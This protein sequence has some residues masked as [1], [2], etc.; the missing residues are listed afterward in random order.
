MSILAAGMT[1]PRPSG[2]LYVVLAIMLVL[3]P[4]LAVLQYQWIGEVSQAERQKLV[5]HLNQAGMQFAQDFNREIL[6]VLA[7]FQRRGLLQNSDLSEWLTQRYDQA[8]AAYPNL[9]RDAFVAQRTDDGLVLQRFAPVGGGFQTT[10]WPAEFDALRLN[11]E[12][13]GR[14]GRTGSLMTWDPLS[15]PNPTFVVAIA[16]DME[17]RSG[18]GPRPGPSQATAWMLLEWN[19]KYFLDEFIPTIV[20]RHFTTGSSADYRVAIVSRGQNPQVIYKSEAGLTLAEMKT[21]DLRIPLMGPEAGGRG[22]GPGPGGPP[23]EDRR[24]RPATPFGP[25]PQGGFGGQRGPGGGGI[26][27]GSWELLVSHRAGSLDSAITSL[28]RRNLAIS[29]GILLLLASS[30]VLVVT[31]SHRARAL[32]QL[33]M[34]FVARVSHE[35]RTPLAIIRS[36]AY[37][38]ATGVVSDEKDVR[39]YASMVQSEGQRLSTMV[40]QILTFSRTDSETYNVKPVDIYEI[41]EK[42]LGTM[43]SA[44]THAH[45]EVERNIAGNLPMVQA[46]ER[47]LVECLQNLLSNA[48]KYGRHETASRILVDARRGDA[49]TVLLSIADSGP[50]IEPPDLPHIFEPFF[51]GKN[52]RSDTPGSG[53]GLNLVRRMMNAQG[54][55]VTVES[56]PGRGARFTLHLTAVVEGAS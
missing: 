20:S 8:I 42:A 16:Q 48:L 25:P 45:Y 32:A 52:A 43:A 23:Q 38:V 3:L 12:S 51:R 39:E 56:E 46:D 50:G 54:G 41:I 5:E 49:N 35:L 13:R 4:T 24:G 53:L 14:P 55:R 1:L 9:I 34:D 18:F 28:R 31:S 27:A 36:A 15:A 29:F 33:Q 11:L 2:T 44:I 19:R 6:Q 21:P 22:R 30:I 7:P 40:D 47:A 26:M 10:E 37:N 17:P